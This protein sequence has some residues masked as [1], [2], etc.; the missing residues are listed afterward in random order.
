MP[1][2]TLQSQE[3]GAKQMFQKS[4]ENETG[5]NMTGKKKG[6]GGKKLTGTKKGRSVP[7]RLCHLT[8]SQLVSKTIRHAV[9]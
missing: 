7:K 9:S 8:G 6:R 3:S 1:L 5:I 2:D 4:Q